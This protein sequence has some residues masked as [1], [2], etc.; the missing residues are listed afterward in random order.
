MYVFWLCSLGCTVPAAAIT[1]AITSE[2]SREKSRDQR[3]ERRGTGEEGRDQS[4]EGRAK[5]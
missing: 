2:E 3:E 5:R 1:E 4:G